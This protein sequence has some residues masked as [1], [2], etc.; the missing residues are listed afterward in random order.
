MGKLEGKVAVI[1]GGSS[2]EALI[3][4]AVAGI[5]RSG[6]IDADR[7]ED[8]SIGVAGLDGSK[9]GAVSAWEWRPSFDV[10]G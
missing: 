9:K 10:N 8:A 2:A 4:V 3:Q 7:E 6:R 5:R 1:T